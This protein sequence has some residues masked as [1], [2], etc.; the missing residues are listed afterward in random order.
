LYTLRS[1][2]PAEGEF[3]GDELR[4]LAF[5][6]IEEPFEGRGWFL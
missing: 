2:R 6:E 5:K 1:H 3:G 4:L